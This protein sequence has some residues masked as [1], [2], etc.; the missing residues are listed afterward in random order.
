MNYTENSEVRGCKIN[1]TNLEFIEKF[2]CTGEEFY[3]AVTVTEVR[4]VVWHVNS[5]GGMN[6]INWLGRCMGQ[7]RLATRMLKVYSILFLRCLWQK[8]LLMTF[9]VSIKMALSVNLYA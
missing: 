2:Q 5:S 3:N 7:D 6:G 4:S 1:T 8:E 9:A